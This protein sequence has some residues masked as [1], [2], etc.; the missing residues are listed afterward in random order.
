MCP[1]FSGRGT[2]ANIAY[3]FDKKG[4][5][6]VKS[7]LEQVFE[8]AIDAG[9]EDV[10]RADG[11]GDGDADGGLAKVVCDFTEVMGVRERLAG[12]GL[13]IHDFGH[14]YIPNVTTALKVG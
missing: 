7:G 9:G 10:L 8:A 14:E 13:D 2:P 12:A 4:V 5:V 1:D 6:T 11:D 3:M